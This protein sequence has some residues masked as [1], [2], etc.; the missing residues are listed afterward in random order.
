MEWLASIGLLLGELTFGLGDLSLEWLSSFGDLSL[1]WPSSFG[2][3]SVC[4]LLFN[5]FG[6]LKCRLCVLL[7]YLGLAGPL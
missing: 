3:L 2:L 1:E 5:L 7:L 6:C 4:L